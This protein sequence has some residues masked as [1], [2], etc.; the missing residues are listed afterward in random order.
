MAQWAFENGGYYN[1]ESARHDSL[2]IQM[3]KIYTF[4]IKNVFFFQF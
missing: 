2:H 3:T 1:D 4:F